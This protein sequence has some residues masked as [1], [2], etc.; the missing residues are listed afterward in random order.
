MLNQHN[1]VCIGRAKIHYLPRHRAAAGV[2]NK[3][4]EQANRRLKL[5][6]Y[7]Y[8]AAGGKD[9]VDNKDIRRVAFD[10]LASGSHFG[11]VCIRL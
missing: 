10:Y 5:F 8:G 2:S 1:A 9:L 7:A 6:R 3:S 4:A 11:K